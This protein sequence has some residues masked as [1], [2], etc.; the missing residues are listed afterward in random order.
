M[1]PNTMHYVLTVDNSITYG[2]HFYASSSMQAAISGIVH[3]F[4][5]NYAVTNVLHPTLD[6]MLR[7]MMAMWALDYDDDRSPNDSRTPHVPNIST[8]SGLMDTM[9]LGN[10]MECAQVLDHRFYSKPGKLP[11]HWM[12]Q[13]EMATARS[14]YRKL[15]ARFTSDYVTIV[16]GRSIWPSSIFRRSLV[17]FAAAIVVY[18][19]DMTDIAPKVTGCTAIT[20]LEDMIAMFTTNYPELL[21]CFHRL[22]EERVEFLHWTGP[23]IT[24]RT[25]TA[26]DLPSGD[27]FDFEDRPIYSAAQPKAMQVEDVAMAYPAQ[28]RASEKDVEMGDGEEQDD[29]EGPSSH[30]TPPKA[31]S[32]RRRNRS[33]GLA[34]QCLSYAYADILC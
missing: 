6:T 12:E 30:P 14:R 24:I 7:R 29:N 25:R 16:G 2:R 1:R 4:V 17:E 10:L 23:P 32:S 33:P 21:P 27:S 22:I 28:E 20:V 15:T 34:F 19:Q 5:M 26:N 3:A 13:Q 31:G 8:V 11:F 9:A 18:K